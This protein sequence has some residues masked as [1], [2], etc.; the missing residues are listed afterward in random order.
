[1][2]S[3][4]D[5]IP[6][7]D[8]TV[9]VGPEEVTQAEA[10]WPVADLYRVEP[11]DDVEEAPS[12]ETVV[13][14]AQKTIGRPARRVPPVAGP[15]ILI[16]IAAVVGALVLAGLLLGRDEGTSSSSAASTTQSLPTTTTPTRTATPA[17]TGT[18]SLPDLRGRSLGDA[19]AALEKAGLRVRVIREDSDRPAGEVLTQAAPAGTKLQKG[20]VVVLTVSGTSTGAAPAEVA[21]PGVVGLSASDAV[22]AIRGAG[23]RARIHLVRSSQAVGTV[24][25]QSPVDGTMAAKGATIRLDVARIQPAPVVARLEVPD[26]V[27]ST[28]TAA[29]RQLRSMGLAVTIDTVDSDQPAGTVV[30]QSPGAGVEVRKGASVTVRVSSGPAKVAV[31]DVTGLDED[32]ARLRLENAG[33]EVSVVDQPTSDPSQ[34]GV[35]LDQRPAGGGEAANSSVVTLTVARLG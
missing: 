16:A 31:P 12:G 34:D 9:V 3:D 11:E 21:V 30:S 5:R 13:V 15:A 1:M 24:I 10:D 8:D 2:A 25:A 19:R 26:L 7:G 18:T 32:A 14:A 35:V 23:F 6:A 4:R 28:S 17:S 29:Q 27:G 22:V 20:D 33:F